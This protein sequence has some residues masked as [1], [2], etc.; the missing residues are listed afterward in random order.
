MQVLAHIFRN[1]TSLTSLSIGLNGNCG[2][3]FEKWSNNAPQTNLTTL[4]LNNVSTRYEHWTAYIRSCGNNL[5]TLVMDRVAF[6][7]CR[8]I[9][10]I[11][12]FLASRLLSHCV[13]RAITVNDKLLFFDKLYESM[14]KTRFE[15]KKAPNGGTDGDDLVEVPITW[16]PS[17]ELHLCNSHDGD[18]EVKKGLSFLL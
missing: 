8:E 12:Q 6:I 18:D 5:K 2:G 17:Y 14:P 11:F 1:T 9:R 7:Q 10:P 15:Y 16:L 13:L 4:H 3:F